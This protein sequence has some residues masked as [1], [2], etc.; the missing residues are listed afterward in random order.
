M[1][2]AVLQLN[3]STMESLFPKSPFLYGMGSGFTRNDALDL[4]KQGEYRV[5]AQFNVNTLDDV[6]AA[7][8]LGQEDV[9]ER[10]ERMHSVSVGDIIVDDHEGTWIVAPT[11][12]DMVGKLSDLLCA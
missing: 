12:F 9:I 11:G 1:S 10:I 4:L 2:F 7:S 3:P 6:Y 5:V 8:N